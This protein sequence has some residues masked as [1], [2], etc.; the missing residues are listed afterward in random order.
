M[1]KKVPMMGS[2]RGELA[3][4]VSAMSRPVSAAEQSPMVQVFFIS[5]R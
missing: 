5:L 2:H 1:A 4:I 3:G